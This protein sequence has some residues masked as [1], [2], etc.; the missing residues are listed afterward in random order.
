MRNI[1][2]EEMQAGR[3]FW[4]RGIEKVNIS[5]YRSCKRLIKKIWY[6]FEPV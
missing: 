5:S 6:K 2:G 1:E 3:I 4:G